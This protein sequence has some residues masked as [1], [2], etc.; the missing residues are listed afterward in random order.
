[1]DKQRLAA[2]TAAGLV[3]AATVAFAIAPAHGQTHLRTPLVVTAPRE[4]PFTELV[5]YG[6][7]ALATN[8]GRWALHHRVGL[9][10]DRVCP[11]L[12]EYGFDYDSQ[13]CKDYAW[14]GA[15]PQISRA[16]QAAR[17]GALVA[18]TI[19]VSAAPRR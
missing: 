9:A 1:M 6:D 3:G 15:R 8:Q 17:S 16:V 7:L 13:G 10:V 12:D 18:M 5:P 14:D 4:G 2:I 19:E 11:D